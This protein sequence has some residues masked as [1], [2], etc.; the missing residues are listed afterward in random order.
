MRV[1]GIR[2]ER[3]MSTKVVLGNF[4]SDQPSPWLG[5]SKLNSGLL[6][7]LWD[8]PPQF[9]NLFHSGAV[10]N[11][12]SKTKKEQ[13]SKNNTWVSSYSSLEWEKYIITVMI[14]EDQVSK[15][16]LNCETPRR[17]SSWVVL[18]NTFL[19]TVNHSHL[20]KTSQRIHSILL[21]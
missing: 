21:R 15:V 7:L 16:F 13:M 3:A 17:T 11:E 19:D 1:L 10:W 20:L 18:K 6:T 12:R 14:Q 4:V 8:T 2:A 5:S 9:L